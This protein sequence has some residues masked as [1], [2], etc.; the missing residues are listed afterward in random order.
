M[1]DKHYIRLELEDFRALISG[2]E[3][4]KESKRSAR[5]YYRPGSEIE[6]HLILADIGWD[7]M[8]EAIHEE[9]DNA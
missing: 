3:V 2:K 8:L 4:I 9:K 7:Q 5:A 6:L 1:P